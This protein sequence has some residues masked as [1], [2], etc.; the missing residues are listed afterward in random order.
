[1]VGGNRYVMFMNLSLERGVIPLS[2][3]E[4]NLNI[5]N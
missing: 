1:M 3:R 2:I 4:Y 5:I